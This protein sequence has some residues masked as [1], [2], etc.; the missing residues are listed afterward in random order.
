MEHGG[1]KKDG[2][3]MMHARTAAAVSCA[4]LAKVYCTGAAALQ[5]VTLTIA[6]GASFGLLG[7]NGAGKS[8]LVR[9]LMGFIFPTL[10]ELRVLGETEVRRAHPRIG[11][12]HE[13]AHAELRL[14]ARQYLTYMGQLSHLWK[15]TNRRRVA[16]VLEQVDLGATADRRIATYSKGMLQRLGIAQ[17]LLAGPEMLILD[18]P[19]GGLDPYSQWAVRQ[20]IAAPRRQGA[21]ILLCSHDLTEDAGAAGRRSAGATRADVALRQARKR[22]RSRS[23]KHELERMAFNPGMVGVIHVLP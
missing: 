18:E 21:T 20:T 11:Y 12:L 15:T 17:A 3:V 2:A 5:D 4:G 1:V 14:T 23:V 6:R 9:L 22:A 16:D 10:G 13:H 7:E 19:T 8:T